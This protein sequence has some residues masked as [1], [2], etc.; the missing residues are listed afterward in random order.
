MNDPHAP[1]PEFT[2]IFDLEELDDAPRQIDLTA[3]DDERALLAKRF[4]QQSIGRLTA[5]LVLVW[6]EPGK[7]LSVSGRFEA[8]VVQTCV[9][10]LESVPASLDEEINLIFATNIEESADIV[11]PDEAEPL[12]GEAIDLGELVAEEL[13]LALDPYPRRPDIDPRS[14]DLGPGVSLI[15]EGE[16]EKGAERANPFEVLAALKPK[17]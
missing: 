11:D 6:L 7:V 12:E 13:S 8:D 16:A 5:N 4:D 1:A 14:I 3:S 9:V 15:S 10:S 2:R 17:P